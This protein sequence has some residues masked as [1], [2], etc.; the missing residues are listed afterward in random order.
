MATL[1]QILEPRTLSRLITRKMAADKWLI[2]FMGFGSANA[3]AGFEANSRNE[4]NL[5]DGRFG[6]FHVFNTT[7]TVGQPRTP[8]APAANVTPNPVG[9]VPF[10]YPRMF[11]SIDLLGETLHNLSRIGEDG[12]RDVAGATYIQKQT[13]Y[14][15]QRAG[16]F[17][18]ALTL[19]MLR[20]ELYVKTTGDMQYFD[21]DSTGSQYQVNFQM[22][23][24]TAADGLSHKD[25]L[26][27]VT[28]GTNII[29]TS[30]DDATANIPLHLAQIDAAFQQ[31]YGGRLDYCICD[32]T[33][34][35]HVLS[36]D[37]VGQQAGIAN[38]PFEEFEIATGVKEDGTPVH[39]KVARLACRPFLNWIVTDEG[40]EMG[41]PG[42]SDSDSAITF[43]KYVD[44]NKVI[45]MPAPDGGPFKMQLG[46]EPVVEFDGGPEAVRFGNW[47]WSLKQTN[48]ARTTIFSLDN[49]LPIND[50]PN[51]TAYGT[52]IF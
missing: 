43:R 6:H 15:A 21:F 41:A 9:D 27:M 3:G 2:S 50:I 18:A 14:L 26:D 38:K 37:F 8:G 13:D 20:D 35:N 44:A 47:A 1:G 7:R 40:L 48:S 42:T 34:F 25:Q 10:R 16:N 17:R 36:N 31:K 19:G 32:S 28:D 4:L 30:W 45:F 46:S 52:V 12:I 29:D 22:P 49:C 33:T 51:S 23:D 5:G 24:G 39:V 11:E